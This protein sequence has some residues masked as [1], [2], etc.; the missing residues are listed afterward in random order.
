MQS[1][2]IVSVMIANILV[3]FFSILYMSLISLKLIVYSRPMAVAIILLLWL[4]AFIGIR[5]RYKNGYSN[6]MKMATERY[7]FPN[8]K[9]SILFVILFEL[10]YNC[11]F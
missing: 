5:W 8:R 3:F 11:R 1:L 9:I 6:V 10:I 7:P 4:M 2:N